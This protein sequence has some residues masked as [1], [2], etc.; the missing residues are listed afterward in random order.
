MR[1]TIRIIGCLMARLEVKVTFTYY[2]TFRVESNLIF[3]QSSALYSA[4]KNFFQK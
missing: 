3:S 4:H 1:D 2:T